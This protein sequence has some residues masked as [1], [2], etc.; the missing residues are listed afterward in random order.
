MLKKIKLLKEILGDFRSS[1]KEL[2]FTCPKCGHHKKKLSVNVH[3]NVFKCWICDWAG[4][5]LATV[6]KN[7]GSKGQWFQWAQLSEIFDLYADEFKHVVEPVTLPEDWINILDP[8]VDSSSALQ[9]LKARGISRSDMIRS[10][11]GFCKSG[12]FKD[13]IVFTSFDLSGNLN[14]YTGRSFKNSFLKYKNSKGTRDIIFNELMIDWNEDIT[15]VEG[16]I[17]SIK[18]KNSIPIL[19]ST[20]REDSKLFQKISTYKNK[21][22]LALD[23]DAHKKE[24]NIAR[25]FLEYGLKVFKIDPGEGRDVGDLSKVKFEKKKQCAKQITRDYLFYNNILNMEI[26]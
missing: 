20:L 7:Y 16:P 8:A 12:P 10:K 5:D 22:Y 17:D 3:K 15:L 26:T 9:Y 13:R 25:R 21:V 18:A 1:G 11:L 14:F 6:V 4:S 19:G 23:K 24:I 2:L